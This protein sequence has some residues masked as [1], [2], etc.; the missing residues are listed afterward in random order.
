MLVVGYCFMGKNCFLLNSKA[1]STCSFSLS[2]NG[3]SV[4]ST[5]FLLQGR[6]RHNYWYVFFNL[7]IV[8]D[9]GSSFSLKNQCHADLYLTYEL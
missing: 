4:S 7:L 8:L 2:G 5:I 3:L 6:P 1:Q 9:L